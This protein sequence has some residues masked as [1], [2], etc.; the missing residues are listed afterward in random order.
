M[1]LEERPIDLLFVGSVNQRR[2]ELIRAIEA[3]GVT[4]AQFDG[5]VY[6][7]ERDSYVRQAKAVLNV[8]FYETARFA[9]A[10]ASFV[11]SQGTPFVSEQQR[12]DRAPAPYEQSTLWFGLGELRPFFA[13]Y[14]ASERFY[15]DARKAHAAFTAYDPLPRVR[16]VW[17]YALE[18]EKSR[19][20]E[21]GLPRWMNADMARRGYCLGQINADPVAGRIPDWMVDLRRPLPLT[22]ELEALAGLEGMTLGEL[23]LRLPNTA[24]MFDNALILLEVGGL[25]VFEAVRPRERDD[26]DAWIESELGPYTREFWRS[27]WLEYRFQVK[28]VGWC[29]KTGRPS[30]QE[31]QRCRVVLQKVGCSLHER[32]R[33]R[34]Q[35]E[36]FGLVP[37]VYEELPNLEALDV[38]A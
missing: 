14:F 21:G 25:L 34:A 38:S 37:D 36:D 35:L 22:A 16:A 15:D 23:D 24:T 33:A 30:T 3:C 27:Q 8:H 32:T 17:D 5:A 26:A 4:V 31:R 6:G 2:M 18:C 7:P 11:L 1:P 20:R 19:V 29:D 28:H 9:Q 13:D 12:S 10:R